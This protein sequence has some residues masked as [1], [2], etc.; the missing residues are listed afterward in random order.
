MF[1]YMYTD[2]KYLCNS[3]KDNISGIIL[4]KLRKE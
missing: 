1:G 4:S 3:I 2:A